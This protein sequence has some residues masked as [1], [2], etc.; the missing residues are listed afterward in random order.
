MLDDELIDYISQVKSPFEEDDGLTQEELEYRGY[1]RYCQDCILKS[2]GTNECFTQINLYW[3][4]LKEKLTQSELEQFITIAISN[5]VKSYK[6]SFL[7]D[8]V[9]REDNNQDYEKKE[10]L[11]L[12][13]EHNRWLKYFTKCLSF[14]DPSLIRSEEKLKVFLDA[15][16]DSFVEKL[17][18]Y[19]SL[20]P[21]LREYFLY[22]SRAD[23]I[24]TLYLI[25]KKDLFSVVIEQ[26]SKTKKENKNDNDNQKVEEVS[27]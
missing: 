4:E 12:F 26:N 15:D 23:G 9:I 7:S 19:K 17:L 1:L 10:K 20:H 3:S 11:F 14:I 22:C 18:K 2:I 27:V 25:L 5:I 21:W 13:L 24:E 6:M 16:Y 8:I